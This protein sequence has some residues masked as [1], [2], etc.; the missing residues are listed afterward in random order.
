MNLEHLED[1]IAGYRNLRGKCLWMLF[2]VIALR[3]PLRERLQRKKSGL[4]DAAVAYADI[5]D[6]EWEESV[7]SHSSER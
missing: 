7:K 2:R 6:L 5:W 1:I 4:E 3:T